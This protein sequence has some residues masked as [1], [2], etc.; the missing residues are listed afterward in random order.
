MRFSVILGSIL[1]S[2]WDAFSH[3]FGVVFFSVFW[4]A[5]L[6]LKRSMRDPIR[7]IFGTP[8]RGGGGVNHLPRPK[9]LAS[10]VQVLVKG[11]LRRPPALNARPRAGGLLFE[12]RCVSEV[13][14][15]SLRQPP[16]SKSMVLLK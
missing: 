10:F 7:V 2:F 13:D 1:E 14:L 12:F 6:K 11:E 16:G 4:N 5:F 15:G 8:G 3:V 9:K